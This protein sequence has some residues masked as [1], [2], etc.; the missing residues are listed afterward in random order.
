MTDDSF[1]TLKA[2]SKKK[3]GVLVDKTLNTKENYLKLIER[4]N[5]RLQLVKSADIYKEIVDSLK[6][7]SDKNNIHWNSIRCLA[8]GSPCSENQ[9][10]FQLCLLHL[11]ANDCKIKVI[12]IY[13]PVFNDLDRKFLQ[14]ELKFAVEKEYVRSDNDCCCYYMPHSPISLLETIIST[15]KPEWMLTN[16]FTLYSSKYTE[17]EYYDKYPYCARIANLHN[18]KTQLPTTGEKPDNDDFEVVVSKRSQRKKTKQFI[19]P[20]VKYDYDSCYFKSS[21]KI[22]YLSGNDSNQPWDYSF[23]DTSFTALY[24]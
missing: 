19:K 3:S 22:V 21:T 12:S 8:L 1:V 11:I 10:L 20:I 14:Q 16:D 4:F 5:S 2:S 15:E 13:D 18:V 17:V 23:S 24:K 7:F 6:Q 9:A